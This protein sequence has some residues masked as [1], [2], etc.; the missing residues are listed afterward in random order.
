MGRCIFAR[1]DIEAGAWS[2]VAVLANRANRRE[3][4][5]DARR[6]GAGLWV[7]LMPGSFLSSTWQAGMDRLEAAADELGAEG[8]IADWEPDHDNPTDATAEAFGRRCGEVALRRRVGITF[9]PSSSKLDVVARAAG[10]GVFGILQ[11]YGR[12]STDP[13]ELARWWERASRYFGLRLCLA[14]ALWRSSERIDTPDEFARYLSILP[15]CGA[16]WAWALADST[17]P[18]WMLEQLQAWEPGGSRLGTLAQA[19]LRAVV[20]PAFAVLLAIG[21]VAVLLVFAIWRSS[22]A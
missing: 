22:R 1:D 7:Y 15:R 20:R 12:T 9:H 4:A 19:G 3:L 2:H 16:G 21:V 14:V 5:D 18:A 10:L 13:D 17:P 11:E 6:R 8:I